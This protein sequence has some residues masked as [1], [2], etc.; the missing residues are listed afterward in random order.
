MGFSIINHPVWGILISGNPHMYFFLHFL[1]LFLT[2]LN[3]VLLEEVLGS[4]SVFLHMYFGFCFSSV[5]ILEWVQ[6]WEYPHRAHE[7]PPPHPNRLRPR[8]HT[9]SLGVDATWLRQLLLEKLP[10]L[11]IPFTCCVLTEWTICLK[12]CTCLD[13]QGIWIL[14]FWT[15]WS[16][17]WMVLRQANITNL[18]TSSESRCDN[19]DEDRLPKCV[20]AISGTR[21]LIPQLWCYVCWFIN[22]SC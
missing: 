16:G 3:S 12:F 8:V 4:C 19:W 15:S 18:A 5:E 20:L 7:A 1:N 21:W 2:T 14:K 22:R 11:P 13:L 9:R 6:F 17:C 10:R